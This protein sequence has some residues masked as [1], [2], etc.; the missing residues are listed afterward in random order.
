MLQTQQILLAEVAVE[1]RKQTYEDRAQ[2]RQAKRQKD[3]SESDVAICSKCKQRGHISARSPLCPQDI[4]SKTQVICANLE[5]NYKA[6]TRKLGFDNCMPY[7][8]ENK[9]R[10][11]VFRAELFVNYYVLE[12]HI[13]IDAPKVIFSQ[14]FWY[15]IIQMA[16]ALQEIFLRFL[17]MSSK[18]A[19]F[20]LVLLPRSQNF[21]S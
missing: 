21:L 11:L 8:T 14:N 12:N 16:N 4:L 5:D 15:S 9:S 13:L 10:R 3:Q 19:G 7:E 1:K 6:Y 18:S 17:Q 20:T 2:R